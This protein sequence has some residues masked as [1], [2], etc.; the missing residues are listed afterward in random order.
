[1]MAQA[2]ISPGKIARAEAPLQTLPN[3]Q[4][5]DTQECEN[6]EDEIKPTPRGFDTNDDLEDD[7]ENA[8]RQKHGKNYAAK[9]WAS[10]IQGKDIMDM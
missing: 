7:I 8:L 1:M 4:I 3:N 10:K 9:S 6:L 5:M 2:G